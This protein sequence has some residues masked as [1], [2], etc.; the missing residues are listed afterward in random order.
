[1]NESNFQRSLIAQEIY[2]LEDEVPTIMEDD[3][4]IAPLQETLEENQR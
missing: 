3:S 1:M 2:P 4:N